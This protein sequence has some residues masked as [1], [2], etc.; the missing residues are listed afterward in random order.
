[1]HLLNIYYVLEITL[2]FGGA[3]PTEDSKCVANRQ[4]VAF[5]AN[6]LTFATL[7]GLPTQHPKELRSAQ[8]PARSALSAPSLNHLFLPLVPFLLIHSDSSKL[9]SFPRLITQTWA[10]GEGLTVGPR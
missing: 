1:M 2:P 3:L 9:G 10:E 5:R 7:P 6:Q 4:I 8:L